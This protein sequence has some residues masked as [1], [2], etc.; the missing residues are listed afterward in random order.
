M[1]GQNRST[2]VMQRR[3]VAPDSLDYFPTPPFATRALI[4]FLKSIGEDLATASAWEPACGEM[5][6]VRP[7]REAFTSVRA[8][9]VHSYGDHE[10]LDFA[11]IGGGEPSVDWVITNPPF[12]LAE[13]FIGT[14]MQVALRG[15]AMLVRSAFLEGEGR[16]RTLFR[17][18]PPSWVLQFTDRVVMLEGRLV[19]RGAVDPFAARAGDKAASATA[20]VWL[21][22][23]KSDAGEMADTRLRW[24]APACARLEREGDYP[25]YPVAAQPPGG[26]F[27]P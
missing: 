11:L 17:E 7:M 4:E 15:V 22:W 24:I 1:G 6:M 21:V 19:R 18:T 25:T 16:W 14:A 5:H 2:A 12:R 13:A 27:D 8:S 10:L 26:M 9:D 20:Y 23:L 3:R